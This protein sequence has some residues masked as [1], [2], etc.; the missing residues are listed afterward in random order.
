MDEMA[1][2]TIR[3]EYH[4]EYIRTSTSDQQTKDYLSTYYPRRG[5]PKYAAQAALK[6]L[7]ELGQQGWELVHMEPVDL[8]R[9]GDVRIGGEQVYWTNI[10][11]CVFK[12]PV[13]RS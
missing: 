11:F 9:N 2:Y 7:D 12:R 1:N 3:W 5:F 10:Y 6:R 8:G 4:M 13:R